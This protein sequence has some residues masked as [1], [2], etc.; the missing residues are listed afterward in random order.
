MQDAVERALARWPVDGV[1]DNPAAWL[2]TVARNRA[3]DVLRRRQTERAK[4]QEVADD[5]PS[6][7]APRDRRR[8][9]DDDRLRLL[10]TCCHPA[11]AAGRP[12]RADAADGRPGCAPA[13]IARAFLVAEATMSQRLL[14]AKRKIAHAGIPYRVPPPELLAERT[15]G[16]LAVA[17][18][19]LQRGLRPARRR[20]R[21]PREAL[22]LAGLLVELMP[23]RRRGARPAGP[24]AAAARPPGHPVRR[25]RRPGADGGAGPSALGP[26]A[27]R[28]GRLA[29]ARAASPGRPPGP[30]RLQA[31][32]AACHA[33]ARDA[34][35]DRLGRGRHAVRRAA[36]GA[37]VAGGRAEPGGGG[38]LPG[39]LRGR[40]GG[41]R[42][43]PATPSWPATTCCRPPG[44][45]SC[46]R[47]GRSEEA[48]TAYT[49]AL[50]LAPGEPERRILERRLGEL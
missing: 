36:G 42:T 40:S 32:I 12:G 3:I 17:L 15:G 35:G 27:D 44:R 26:G 48:R 41:A 2:T 22:R 21:W 31:A 24:D 18:P 29:A 25:R 8:P 45:T 16:V 10:F 46:V 23:E 1:P 30:Y 43:A 14:R 4:L 28:R 37:A 39:R 7:N 19:D 11:L 5:A 13:E 50:E 34:G 33:A 20:R 6:S 38:R 47:A 49:A 9:V